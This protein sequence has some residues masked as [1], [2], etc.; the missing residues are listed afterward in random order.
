MT[1]EFLQGAMFSLMI[2][3]VQDFIDT[4]IICA[5]YNRTVTVWDARTGRLVKTYTGHSD[6]VNT[7]CVL[8][9][10]ATRPGSSGSGSSSNSSA[11]SN[12]VFLSGSSDYTIRAYRLR[13]TSSY[14]TI[15]CE[16]NRDPAQG[17]VETV[18]KLCRTDNGFASGSFD[19]TIRIWGWNVSAPERVTCLACLRGSFLLSVLCLGG[20]VP[21][22]VCVC[23]DAGHLDGIW[24]LR[25]LSLPLLGPGARVLFSGSSDTTI[26]IWHLD[27]MSCIKVSVTRLLGHSP[28]SHPL[29]FPHVC[30]DSRGSHR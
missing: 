2:A 25:F 13:D 22:S 28:R 8:S 20:L 30:A 10:V 23:V 24:S 17:H 9:S 7:V 27:T 3:C 6:S 15:G 14:M 18:Q 1:A 4:S 29:T 19:R 11:N 5:G 26:R 12:Q 21:D 16:W